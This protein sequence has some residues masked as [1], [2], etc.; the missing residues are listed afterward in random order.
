MT[1]EA[2]STAYDLW[3]TAQDTTPTF[4]EMTLRAGNLTLRPLTQ[5]D[6]DDVVRACQDA[7][8]MRWLPLPRPYTRANAEWFIG[9]F[10]P[11]LRESGAGIVFAVESAGRLA[12]V[13][14]LKH[15]NWV[16]KVAEV[17]YWVAPW[18]RGRGVASGATRALAEWA[19]G[20]H[21]FERVE[22]FAATGNAASQRAAEKA[23][24]VREGVARNAGYVHDGRVDMVVFSLVPD[25]LRISDVEDLEG[26]RVPYADGLPAA[27]QDHLQQIPR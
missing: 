19:I 17:G 7:E 24:F 23:G 14:D 4:P 13:I 16:A 21:G 11:G 22:L 10:G 3:M 1:S 18:A 5:A 6:A 20:G 8:T 15:V 26:D 12:G 25:D 27:G 2:W 9:S